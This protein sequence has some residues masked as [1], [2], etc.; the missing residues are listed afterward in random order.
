ME[1]IKELSKKFNELFLRRTYETF[2]EEIAEVLSQM[3]NIPF[4]EAKDLGHAVMI[5]SS[6]SAAAGLYTKNKILTAFGI[7]GW[8]VLILMRIFKGLKKVKIENCD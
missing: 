8:V 6:I 3:F 5:I 7:T 4:K 2:S 1:E